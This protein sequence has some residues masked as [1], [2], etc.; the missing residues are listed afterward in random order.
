[1]TAVA[2]PTILV[3]PQKLADDP[4]L[5]PYFQ[6]LDQMLRG[7]FTRSGGGNDAVEDAVHEVFFDTTRMTAEIS[8]LRQAFDDLQAAAVTDAAAATASNPAAPTGY[9]PHASGAVAVTSNAATDLDTTAAAL[10][11]LVDEVAVVETAVSA[12]IVDSA[13]I[14]TQF[15]DLLDKL[16]TAELLAT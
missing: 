11:T 6:A 9:T 16:R 7:L 4:E 3:V 1:M 5:G 2:P 12:A 8:V 15:N 14:R 10:D 13:D